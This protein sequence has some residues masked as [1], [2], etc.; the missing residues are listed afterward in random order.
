MVETSWGR[1]DVNGCGKVVAPTGYDPGKI[2]N[3]A[4]QSTRQ[5]PEIFSSAAKG[6][7]CRDGKS[8]RSL[9][10]VCGREAVFV[11]GLNIL[12]QRMYL[13]ICLTWEHIFRGGAVGGH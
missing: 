9:Q 1:G 3:A 13:Y 6:H 4:A 7:V 2:P 12:T 10:S 5:A 11:E 8:G